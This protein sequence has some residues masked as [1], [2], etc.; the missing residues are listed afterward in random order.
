MHWYCAHA[1]A[2][3]W[4]LDVD[5]EVSTYP[6][7]NAKDYPGFEAFRWFR[8]VLDQYAQPRLVVPAANAGEFRD[9]Y[10]ALL[11]LFAAKE[12]CL[13]PNDDLVRHFRAY[14]SGLSQETFDQRIRLRRGG[15]HGLSPEEWHGLVDKVFERLYH[16]KAGRG[17]TMPSRPPSFRAYVY[18]ALQG[19]LGRMW[20][21]R[22]GTGNR[23]G[24][25]QSVEE[26]AMDLGVSSMTVRRL[27]KRLGTAAWSPE[28]WDA[29]AQQLRV[30]KHWQEISKELERSGCKRETARKR[31]QRWKRDGLTPTQAR[32]RVAA[33][34]KGVCAACGEA[35]TIGEWLRGQ[36]FC[37]EC[38][39][40]KSKEGVL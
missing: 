20:G 12:E 31:V 29:V 37:I 28:T 14:C 4:R 24:V 11:A 1:D 5:V 18:K 27:M 40:E 15:P 30:K 9:D 6:W 8:S 13:V 23:T 25:P 22:Q 21:R 16:G 2:P 35:N 10:L 26:A 34:P 32:R 39:V 17:F 36:F 38:F 33:N 7:P 3:P 19:E